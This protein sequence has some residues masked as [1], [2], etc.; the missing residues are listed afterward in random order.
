MDVFGS[1]DYSNPSGTWSIC[2]T[3]DVVQGEIILIL[4]TVQF[5]CPRTLW[6]LSIL[7]LP[8]GLLHYWASE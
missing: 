2:L 7:S 5:S 1:G 8:A 3:S 4:G 6:A